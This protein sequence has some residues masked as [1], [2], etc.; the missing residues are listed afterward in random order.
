MAKS[1]KQSGIDV[2]WYLISIDRLKQI[3]LVVLLLLL[4]GAG[5][6]F[7]HNQ[8]GNPK[9]NAESAIADARQAL[10]SVA[11]S[12]DFNAHRAEFN[13]AQRRLDDAVAHLAGVR[14]DE[15][16]DGAVEAL[17]IRRAALHLPHPGSHHP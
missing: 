11:A 1:R 4:A 9:S 7:W 15:A 5:W 3:G 13:R 12:P 10:N 17:T 6:W 8:K 2:D 16:P 14:F